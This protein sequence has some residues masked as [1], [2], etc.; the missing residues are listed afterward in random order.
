MSKTAVITGA[1]SGIGAAYAK[2]LAADS[3]DLILT[4]RRQDIIQKLADDLTEKHGIKVKVIIAELSDDNDI[5]KVVD[6][7]NSTDNVEVL[8][9]NAGFSPDEEHFMGMEFRDVERMIKVHQTVPV[10][11]GYAVVPKMEQRSRGIIINVSSM[12]AFLPSPNIII[13]GATK[14]F[15]KIFSESLYMDLRRKGI[16]VQVLCPRLTRT[17]FHRELT[18]EKYKMISSKYHW[19]TADEVVD[20]SL[21]CLEKN[22]GPICIPGVRA[23]LYSAI[24]PALPK[25][26][27]YKIA[28]KMARE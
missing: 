14:A 1:T 27:Y 28:E 4:G 12:G 15:L 7:I 20:Y 17:D 23:K 16:K 13:Y 24:V 5:Q 26:I 2:R 9:N 8:I 6:A 25:S 22:K 21:R 3:Y 11:L 18:Q 10:R 19:M